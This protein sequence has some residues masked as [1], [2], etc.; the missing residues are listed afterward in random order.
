MFRHSSQIHPVPD[1]SRDRADDPDLRLIFL[2]DLSL[3]DMEFQ[4][5]P[6][7]GDLF[8][9]KVQTAAGKDLLQSLPVFRSQMSDILLVDFL[10]DQSASDR[11]AAEIARLL[12]AECTDPQRDPETVLLRPLHHHKSR[13][14]TRDAVIA[15]AVDHGIEMRTDQ[16]IPHLVRIGH[17]SISDLIRMDRSAEFPAESFE[18]L[19][20]RVLRLRIAKSCHTS[21]RRAPDLIKTLKQPFT[22]LNILGF[23]LHMRFLLRMLTFIVTVR[24]FSFRK[25]I[26]SMLFLII[27]L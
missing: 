13:D 2:E 15:A 27:S 14:H 17:I 23:M 26:S 19:M 25:Q 5:T 10:R 1:R 8:R 21:L 4:I 6:H 7:T 12:T 20:H 3:L 9:M 24:L 22:V 16:R 18:D 11:T